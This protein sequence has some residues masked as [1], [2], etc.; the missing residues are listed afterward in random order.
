MAFWNRN[1]EESTPKKKKTAWQEWKET[2][3][4]ALVVVPLINIFV[5]QSYAIPTSSMEG[6]MLVGDKLFV[7]KFHYGV[8]IPNTPLSLPFMH[9]TIW[10]TNMNS[11]TELLSLPDWRLPALEGIDSGDICVFNWPV[12]DTLT[13]QYQSTMSYHQIIREEG[14][15]AVMRKLGTN[16]LPE[17]TPELGAKIHEL[18]KKVTDKKYEI[19]TR[20]TDKKENYVKRCVAAAG[21]LFEIKDG[22]LF[23]NGK[24]FEDHEDVQHAY[25]VTTNG[26]L[27]KRAFEKADIE[28]REMKRINNDKY[29]LHTNKTTADILR[30]FKSVVSVEQENA[31]AG[32]FS[33]R[34]FPNHPDFP[35]TIDNYGPIYMPKEGD[36][37]EMTKE[38][39]ILYERAIRVYEE[40]PSLQWKDGQA[41]LEGQPIDKYKFQMDYH[42]MVGDN[43]HNSQDSRFWGFV[44]KNHITGKPI[45]VW[46]STR[47]DVPMSNLGRKINWGKCFRLL[48]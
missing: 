36:E 43:R 41:Y 26:G 16:T 31:A 11:Y 23:V 48:R 3:I 38:N 27:S 17:Y 13:R 20:P 37:L 35:W 19:I 47:N 9:N 46:L 21:D 8:K 12:G 45:F 1:K 39:Y 28:I 10:R 42:F 5:L 15:A 30:G 14:K 32:E 4:F 6:S 44:P 24:Q 25:I 29:R 7:S 40:N 18:G 33:D 2:I 34:I 22:L